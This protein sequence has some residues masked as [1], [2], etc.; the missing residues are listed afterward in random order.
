[1]NIRVV[2][3]AVAIKS[4][5]NDSDLGNAILEALDLARKLDYPLKYL[6]VHPRHSQWVEDSGG[7]IYPYLN[8]KIDPRI[9]PDVSF[10]LCAEEI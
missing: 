10:Y 5:F 1:M 6:Y 7:W 9:P 2:Q 8:G 4:I 3:P